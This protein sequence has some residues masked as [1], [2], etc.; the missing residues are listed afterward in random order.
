[1]DN[2]NDLYI[3]WTTTDPITAE[4]MVF[5]HGLNSLRVVFPAACGVKYLCERVYT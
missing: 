5:M 3:L 1:M 4:K 2:S